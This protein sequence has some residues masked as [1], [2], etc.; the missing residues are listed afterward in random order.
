MTL[1]SQY[2][3]SQ[4]TISVHTFY[5]PGHS[6]HLKHSHHS[7]GREGV[8][9]TASR[10][11]QACLA[12]VSNS[13]SSQHAHDK[14]HAMSAGAALEAALTQISDSG[15]QPG[16]RLGTEMSCT[17]RSTTKSTNGALPSAGKPTVHHNQA[18]AKQAARLAST[19]R[20]EK[21]Q[22]ERAEHIRADNL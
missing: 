20:L 21:E 13:T 4:V 15:L 7:A 12:A 1:S 11:K 2:A 14:G 9:A 6:Q 5:Q 16:S 22:A 10:T 8:C 3:L 17:A 18:R 19:I